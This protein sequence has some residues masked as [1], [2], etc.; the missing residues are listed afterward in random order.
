MGFLK[1][2]AEEFRRGVSGVDTY[3]VAG[4]TVTCSH[5]G[6]QDFSRDSRQLNTTAL[7]FFDLD[8]ANRNATIYICK[9]CGHIEWFV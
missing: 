6:G 9:N 8:W 4:K 1:D 3:E 7:T 2:T 5:C